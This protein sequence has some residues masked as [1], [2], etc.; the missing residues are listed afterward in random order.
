[1]DRIDFFKVK[2]TSPSKNQKEN[3]FL[4]FEPL[5]KNYKD[6]LLKVIFD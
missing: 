3:N 5:I 2:N 6:L 4:W 1:M